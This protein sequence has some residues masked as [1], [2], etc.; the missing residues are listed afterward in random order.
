MAKSDSQQSASRGATRSALVVVGVLALLGL[1][2]AIAR[3][4]ILRARIVTQEIAMESAQRDLVNLHSQLN[5]LTLS[6]QNNAA[7]LTQ[8]H[9]DLATISSNVGD[10]H[11]R[12]E[13]MRRTSQRGEALYLLRLANDQLQLG[14]DLGAATDTLSA[15]EVTLRDADDIALDNIHRQVQTLLTQLQTLP[16]SDIARIQQQ[17]QLATQ[18]VN[19]LPL[20]GQVP[21][22]PATAV[23]DSGLSRGW[24]VLKQALASLF[25][26]RRTA[27]DD[28]QL[29]TAD[30][31]ALRRRHLQLLLLSA[32]SALLMHQQQA[33]SEALTG[34]VHWLDSAFAGNDAAVSNLRAQL[35]ALAQQNVAPVLPD[36]TPPIQALTRLAAEDKARTATP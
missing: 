27:G 11:A 33:Y 15:A 12:A 8:L 16:R 23:A 4:D 7:Q 28:D 5:A 22:S 31:Q 21:R 24:S 17:L 35:A 6:V 30:E 3:V 20:A 9:D 19:S 14:H 18:Q 1:A 29:L 13:Q 32:R 25:V 26:V 34:S 2:Y 36:L 10:V